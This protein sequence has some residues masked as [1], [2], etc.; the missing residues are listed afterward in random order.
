MATKKKVASKASKKKTT[1]RKNAKKKN[2]RGSFSGM[3]NPVKCDGPVEIEEKG[4][5]KQVYYLPET[6][7]RV[8]EALK[9][10]VYCLDD[11]FVDVANPRVTKDIDMLV[12][13]IKRF[14]FRDPIIVNK[15]NREIEAGHQRRIALKQRLSC[16]YAAMV[17]VDD[18]QIEQ[19]AYNL[20]DNRSSEVVATWDDEGLSQI[21]A[22]LRDDN[23]L[24]GVGFD[25]DSMISVLNRLREEDREDR[26]KNRNNNDGGEGGGGGGGTDGNGGKELD[27]RYLITIKCESEAHQIEL[28][29]FLD[30]NDID[31]TASII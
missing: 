22:K 23:A 30:E 21:Y 15:R 8:P 7:I 13:S 25:D 3:P 1:T 10:I 6:D 19:M 5:I 31:A 12:S 17:F 28:L 14:G 16:N 9:D 26:N 11:V 2:D 4:E 29:E 20:A 24:D 27:H 18:D